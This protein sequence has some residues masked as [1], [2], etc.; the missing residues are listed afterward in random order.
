MRL[1]REQLETF[2]RV[3]EE[4]SFDKA[5]QLLSISKGAV[6]QRIKALEET[7]GTRV[8][9][10]DKPIAPTPSGELL[11]RYVN[12]LRV[13]EASVIRK[14]VP[15]AKGQSPIP[16][17]IAVNADSLATWIRQALW[18]IGLQREVLLEVVADDQEHTALR[19]ARG[20][21]IGCVTIKAEAD[22]GFK[23]EALGQM[24]YRC[25][26][27]PAFAQQ[28]FPSGLSV[29]SAVRAPAVLFNRKDSLHEE[30]LASRFGLEIHRYG[31]QY[32][33]SPS[34]LLEGI[35][36]GLGYGLVP[37]QQATLLVAKGELVDLAPNHPVKVSLYWH[38]WE[39]EPPAAHRITEAIVSCA[40]REL[41][42]RTA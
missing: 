39:D 23:A 42:G 14:I 21:V 36:R 37:E 26:A 38:H 35:A 7:L 32:L 33:P 20:E 13:N 8:L 6:S 15:D 12:E 31:R 4:Q 22:V 9:G 18:E 3:A 1:D 25:Y 10:R 29:E 27:S 41:N 5:A 24:T 19:L 17:A 11:L 40:S 16:I 2:A 28:F 34:E 30:F